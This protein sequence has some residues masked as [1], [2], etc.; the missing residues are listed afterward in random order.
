MSHTGKVLAKKRG[1]PVIETS[2]M[3][4]PVQGYDPEKAIESHHEGKSITNPK[5]I[6]PGVWYNIHTSAK[7][8]CSNGDY[9]SKK[10]FVDLMEHYRKNFSCMK[11]RGHIDAYITNHPFDPYWK[12][13]DGTTKKDIGLFKWSWEFHNAVNK[14]IGNPI[15]DWETAY[16]LY[17]GGED[18]GGVCSADCGQ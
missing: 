15:M 8:A 13:I 2:P 11:C 14:R 7:K 5:Y 1:G 17:F 10:A 16:G 3:I 4:T 6:G 12:V 18:G 9:N